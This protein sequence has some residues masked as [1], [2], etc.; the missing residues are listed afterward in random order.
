MLIHGECSLSLFYH[1]VAKPE[2]KRHAGAPE[3]I[4]DR[5]SL[6]GP[7]PILSGRW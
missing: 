6:F 7:E 2:A 1:L 3:T 4:D 5:N